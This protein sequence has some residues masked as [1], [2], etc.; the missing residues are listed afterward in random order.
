MGTEVSI[1]RYNMKLILSLAVVCLFVTKLEARRNDHG[2]CYCSAKTMKVINNLLNKPNNCDK[3]YKCY[4]AYNQERDSFS[5]ECVKL[6]KIPDCVCNP[7]KDGM[8]VSME[9]GNCGSG[10]I[11]KCVHVG[12]DRWEGKCLVEG[13][14]DE[15]DIAADEV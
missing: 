3:G 12:A 9:T 6:D 5:G 8:Y 13:R 4:C 14:E 11:C 7:N 15:H 2:E 1:S 10:K